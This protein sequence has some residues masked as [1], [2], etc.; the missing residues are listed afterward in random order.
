MEM[1][2]VHAHSFGLNRARTVWVSVFLVVSLAAFSMLSQVF[3][4]SEIPCADI[5]PAMFFGGE[6]ETAKLVL[7]EIRLPRLCAALLCGSSLAVAGVGMQSLFRNP[8]ADPSVTGVS[9]GAALGAVV[10][11]TFFGSVVSGEILA[12]VF[13]LGA[14]FAVCSAGSAFSRNSVYSVLLA[15]IAVNAFCGALVGFFMYTVRDA[16]MRGFVFWSLGSLE[17]CGWTELAAAFA[18][19]VPSQILLYTQ[20]RAMNLMLLG[21]ESAFHGGVDVRRVRLC[22]I[23]ASAV[24]TAACVSICGIIGFVGLVVPHILRM[25]TTPDNRVLVPL[26]A[27]GGALLLVFADVSARAVSQTDPVPI[28]VIT[29]LLGAPFFAFL[30]KSKGAGNG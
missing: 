4:S 2:N 27:L 7:W 23:A 25:S 22:V 8:L 3:G 30:L 18:L 21:E 12:L 10:A 17:R 16:G 14:A 13:G 15:G 11:L 6:N 20:S 5:F 26:S 1:A 24:M 28:G 29:A 19:C 9:S